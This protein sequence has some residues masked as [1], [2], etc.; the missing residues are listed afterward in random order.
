MVV[1]YPALIA[2]A[3]FFASIIVNLR[4]KNNFGAF[5]TSLLAI[6]T[7]LFIVFL[8]QKNLDI[9]AYVLILVPIVLVYVG[10]SLGIKRDDSGQGISSTSIE[11]TK[12]TNNKPKVPERIEPIAGTFQCE[13]CVK[14]PCICRFVNNKA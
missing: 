1:Y 6:P 14:Y 2:S 3:I 4:D 9:I 13:K 5:I 11:P 7:V 8:C 10:Y 12:D